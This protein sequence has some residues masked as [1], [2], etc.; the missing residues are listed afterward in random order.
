MMLC[1][2]SL[3]PKH[4]TSLYRNNR[5]HNFFLGVVDGNLTKLQKVGT[6]NVHILK[7]SLGQMSFCALSVYQYESLIFWLIFQVDLQCFKR[8]ACQECVG[9][10]GIHQHD[11]I[12]RFAFCGQYGFHENPRI[13]A[14]RDSVQYTVMR[15]TITDGN[16]RQ[17][18]H[19]VNFNSP[20][21]FTHDIFQQYIELLNVHHFE[22]GVRNQHRV[23]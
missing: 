14:K 3:V 19:A 17:V 9:Q 11:G 13:V 16:L 4:C 15:D 1:C 22:V 20:N 21:R 6:Q 18:L 2:R 12:Q 10:A 23:R 5:Y 8:P 7:V